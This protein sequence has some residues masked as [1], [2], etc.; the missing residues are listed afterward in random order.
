MQHPVADFGRD[1]AHPNDVAV[2]PLVFSVHPRA[3]PPAVAPRLLPPRILSHFA[4]IVTLDRNRL[5]DAV[6]ERP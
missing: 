6:A 5:R 4:E 3:Q 2:A 1:V